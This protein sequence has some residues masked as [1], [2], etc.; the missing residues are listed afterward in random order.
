MPQTITLPP[1]FAVNESFNGNPVHRL[2]SRSREISGTVANYEGTKLKGKII[3]PAK[4]TDDH[5]LVVERRP[6]SKVGFANVILTS[7]SGSVIETA[8]PFDFS[9][10]IWI[11]HPWKNDNGFPNGF[12]RHRQLEEVVESW[13]KS[14][15]Y[16]AADAEKGTIGLRPPQLGAVHTVH[17]HW[18]VSNAV[19]TIVMPT[20]TGKTETMLSILVSRPCQKTLV[21]VPT[22]ALR[23]QLAHKFMTL[24]ILKEEGCRVLS[25]K[26]LFPAVG[27]LKH[28]PKD[29]EQVDSLFGSCHVIVTTSHIVGQC[30]QQIQERMASHC[31]YL[32]IDEA[33]HVEAPTWRVF[34]EKFSFRYVLQFTA[35]PFREDGK[36]VD[37]KILYKYPLKKAQEEGYFETIR[38]EPV[39]EFDPTKADDAIAAKAIEQLRRDVDFNHILMARVESVERAK[40]VYSIYEKYRE[41]AP[42]QLHSGIKSKSERDAVRQKVI[43]GESKIIV[44][45]DML[46]EGFD[47]PELKIAA[48]HDIRKSLAV[49]LQLAG[50]F[51]RSRSDLGNATFIANVADI[52][53]QHEL[54]RLYTRDPDWNC[55]L[56]ELSEGV[57]QEQMDLREFLDGFANFPDDLPLN[58]LRPA[59]STVIYKTT[60]EEWTPERFADGIPGIAS[61]ARVHHVINHE[62]KTLV[63]VTARKVPIEWIENDDVYN[64]DWDLFIVIWDDQQKL[65][66]INNSHNE[67]VFKSLAKAVAGNDV[68]LISEQ[69]VFRSFAGVMRLRL[70]NVGLTEQ[71]GRLVRYTGRMGSDVESGISEAQRR[72]ARKSVLMGTGFE[73]GVKVTVGASRKGRIWS[74]HRDHIEALVRWCKRIGTKVTNESI[75]PDEVLTGTLESKIISKRPLKMPIAVDWPEDVYKDTETSFGFIINGQPELQLQHADITLVNQ[76]EDGD[77]IIRI[78]STNAA[79]QM[80]L[81]LFEVDGNMDYRF[82]LT[83]QQNVAVRHRSSLVPAE[84]FFYDNPP[85]IW[86]VDGSSLEG[87]Q[88]TPLKSTYLPYDR[89]KIS[90]WDWTGVDLTKE[91][92]GVSKR[93]DT[94]QYKV[95][96]VLKEQSFDIVF[97]DDGSGESADVVTVKVVETPE[98]N[99]S[100]HVGFYHCK[101][102]SRKPGKRIE[103]LYEVCG[104]ALKSIHWMHNHDKQTELFT[105]LL[106][107][108]PKRSKKGEASRF[109]K[110]DLDTLVKIK[111]MSRLAPITLSIFIVQ[112]GLSKK[113]ATPEQLELL[114]VTENHLLE[115]YNLPFGV[116]SSA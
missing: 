22:D 98:M 38:F 36:P 60:C 35:T 93:S 61:F 89:E 116:V 69:P 27:V 71:F 43:S 46:G 78:S 97:D 111:E 77:L 48:F 30:P 107:R 84:E 96:E 73:N 21:V 79:F 45:V 55:I 15:S 4:E 101:Y 20:G 105:H 37:G 13:R 42:V 47:L 26:A 86:F 95:I 104:Q 91:S 63:I 3:V 75:D 11:Q 99:R 49:T 109:E 81:G 90:A 106:R 17:G 80:K 31:E 54:R 108:E 112:P 2:I 68:A 88:H 58:R 44:C 70:K 10:G 103:D 12:D 53:V 40:S 41:F 74:H 82:T 114:S 29:Y 66:Y 9:D 57:I 39:I 83:G 56:P 33:H 8:S 6:N 24:G 92:Q 94:V 85:A 87:N 100:I 7:S 28:K 67:G 110:G 23:T 102:S 34:K 18:S 25:E 16:I 64:W 76:S 59:T 52:N 19:G 50:R 32:F 62:R 65:L 115:T 51:T 5:I 14:F 72:N 113:L 1:I